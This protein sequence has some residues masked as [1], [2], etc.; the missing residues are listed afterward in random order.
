[1]KQKIKNAD[2]I[3]VFKISSDQLLQQ[4]YQIRRQ[5]FMEEQGVSLEDEFD[6]FDDKSVHYLATYDNIPAGTARW[7]R[8][9]AGIKLER[10]A[11]LAE[12]RGNGIAKKLL[13]KVMRDVLTARG[14][15]DRVFLHAQL[16]AITLYASVGFR[17][18]GSEF[19]ECDIPH[20]E[21]EYALPSSGR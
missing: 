13:E 11:V 5:V 4:A 21:M 16:E 2:L 12:L 17:K 3:E 6:G 10:F 15:S 7:R 20:I 19:L 1:M 9:E 14:L 18:V 8:I